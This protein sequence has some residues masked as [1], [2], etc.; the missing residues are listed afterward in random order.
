M[1]IYMIVALPV[2][3]VQLIIS[4]TRCYHQSQIDVYTSCR[5]VTLL[6]LPTDLFTDYTRPDDHIRFTFDLTPGF[7]RH[8]S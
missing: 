6:L 4:D 1:N 5:N 8:T 7:K 2:F 3:C